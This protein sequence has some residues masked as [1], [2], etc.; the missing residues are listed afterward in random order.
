M[1]KV[2]DLVR[3]RSWKSLEAEYGLTPD[4]GINAPRK[5]PRKARRLCGE[6]ARVIGIHKNSVSGTIC[7]T[8]PFNRS[9][10]LM[11]WDYLISID[12][13]EVVE[14]AEISRIPIPFKV[15]D[16][17]KVR[18]WK[19]M[20]KEFGLCRYKIDGA[21]P[22]NCYFPF[23]ETMNYFTVGKEFTIHAIDN[24]SGSIILLMENGRRFPHCMSADMLEAV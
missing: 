11:N 7:V 6:E 17:V 18:P 22:I 4:G 23:S 19:D 8:F 5:F 20:E 9:D 12:W 21:L 1:V 13:V 3:I 14:P 10:K 24:A 16:R 2:G 15:G